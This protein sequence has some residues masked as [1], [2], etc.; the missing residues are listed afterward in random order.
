MSLLIGFIVA[1]VAECI[2]HRVCDSKMDLLN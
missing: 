2:F 1:V